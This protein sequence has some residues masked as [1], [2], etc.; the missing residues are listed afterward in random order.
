[1]DDFGLKVGRYNAVLPSLADGDPIELQ[2]DSNGRLLVQ[3]DVSVV[4]DFLGLNGAADN[5]NVLVVGTEDG[6]AVGTAHALRLAADGAVAIQDNG[7]SITVDAI[8]LDIRDLS[9]SQDSVA[10]SDGTD[11]LEVNADGSINVAFAAGAQIQITDGVDTLAVNADGS[12]N[13]VV[14]ATDLDIR[15]LSSA[16]DSVEAVQA[17]HDNLNVNANMQIGDVDVG[18]ANPVP[19]SDNGGSLTVDATDLDIRDLSAAQDNV[20]I[21][22]GVDTL[23]VNADGSINAVVSATDLDIRDL[24]SATDS[25]TVVATDLDV[26]DLSATQD[27]VAI[28]D[29]TDQ[30]EINADGSI[31]VQSSQVLDGAEVY[32]ITDNQAASGDGEYAI[33]GTY[34]DAF[35]AIAVGAGTTLHIYGWQWAADTEAQARIVIDDNGTI[36]VLKTSLNS[37]A[38]PSVD[39]HFADAGRIEVEGAAN[40]SVKVQIKT[41]KAGGAGNASAS[42]HARLV[43]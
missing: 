38:M 11:Q 12:I 15:D 34:S 35:T 18:A 36:S 27:N 30:L 31:N 10:I 43:S 8:D 33:T 21:S 40:R 5:S 9:A 6:T 22:D 26:R 4:M 14:T 3:A 13:S 28:S 39:S 17:T 32:A 24:N 1:M 7:G 23:A 29:G 20:A 42:L 37:S 25:V 2:V 16:T 41:R 19:V